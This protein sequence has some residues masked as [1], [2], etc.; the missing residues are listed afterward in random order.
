MAENAR[1]GL[2]V[3]VPK[4]PDFN[5][6]FSAG[7]FWLAGPT[8]VE[9]VA[10]EAA[11]KAAVFQAHRDGSDKRF[12]TEEQATLLRA[13]QSGLLTLLTAADAARATGFDP[14]GIAQDEDERKLLD[15]HRKK[16]AAETAKANEK[17][18]P[19]QAPKK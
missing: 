19:E 14:A 15:E 7:E 2:V 8:P 4:R 5:G 16:K 10:D 11:K 13:E 1:Q 12:I 3:F 6:F 17:K 9:V 18:P